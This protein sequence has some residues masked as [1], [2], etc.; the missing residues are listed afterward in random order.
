MN[1]Y[2]IGLLFFQILIM[3]GIFYLIKYKS[4]FT[5]KGKQ[6]AVKEDI[7]V[8]TDKVEKIKSDF[9]RE[10]EEIK[11]K[12]LHLLTLQQSHRNEERNVIIDF[13]REYNECLFLMIEINVNNYEHYNIKD[14]VEK[15]IK[16]NMQIKTINVSKSL[17][18]LLVKDEDIIVKSNQLIVELLEFKSLIDN[19]LMKL[20]IKLKSYDNQFNKI[21]E[22]MP[23][24]ENAKDTINI[25]ETE[26]QKT[27]KEII[28]IRKE[29]FDNIIIQHQR[30][31]PANNEFTQMV[32]KYLTKFIL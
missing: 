7:E 30:I 25:F 1:L 26:N 21:M 5:E 31:L 15:R 3:F 24:Y 6:L 23:E 28:E 19:N 29:F 14:L 16:I 17:M 2:D 18:K 8:I 22:L 10:N 27:V 4:Y 11:A 13:Y 20:Q 32:K 12:L 9:Q